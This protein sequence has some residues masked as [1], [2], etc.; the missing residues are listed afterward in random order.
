MLDKLLRSKTVWLNVLGVLVAVL[1]LPE[2]VAIVPVS[3]LPYVGAVLAVANMAL[4]SLRAAD[5][6]RLEQRG[7]VR[8]R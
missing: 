5:D 3:A 8:G 7:Q 2:F 1:A 6:A 4:R